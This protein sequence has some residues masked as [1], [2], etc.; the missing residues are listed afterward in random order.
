MTLIRTMGQI[1]TS[2]TIPSFRTCQ[3]LSGLDLSASDRARQ[4]GATAKILAS[5]SR[6]CWLIKQWQGRTRLLPPLN[7]F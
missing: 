1:R 3:T 2:R 7:N 6:R 5:E 4:I